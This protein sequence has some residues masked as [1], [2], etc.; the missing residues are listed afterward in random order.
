MRKPDF[1]LCENKGADQL[2][3]NCTADQHLCFRY[4]DSKILL[5]LKFQN[6]KPIAFFRDCTGQYVSDRVGNPK[7]LVFSGKGSMRV[8]LSQAT[9]EPL[10]ENSNNLGSDKGRHIPG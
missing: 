7:L 4:M 6:I 9:I 1:C 10:H 2:C 5:L 8:G 3:S